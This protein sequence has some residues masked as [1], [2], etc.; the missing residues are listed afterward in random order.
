MQKQHSFKSSSRHGR[1]DVLSCHSKTNSKTPARNSHSSHNR[2]A[3]CDEP[4]V[5]KL[6][7]AGD[8]QEQEDPREHGWESGE[9][10]TYRKTVGECEIEVGR[11]KHMH[12]MRQCSSVL[13]Q[14]TDAPVPECCLLLPVEGWE[15]VF[16]LLLSVCLCHS[17]EL[18]VVSAASLSC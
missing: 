18:S 2:H 3:R 8:P 11:H 1:L 4:N 13:L 5:E 9:G 6:T 17:S 10:E 12:E 15:S 14:G 16:S 7:V